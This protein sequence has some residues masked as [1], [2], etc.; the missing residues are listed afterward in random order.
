[1]PLRAP[2]I[3]HIVVRLLQ[4]LNFSSYGRSKFQP[5]VGDQMGRMVRWREPFG[6]VSY[7]EQQALHDAE[8]PALDFRYLALLLFQMRSK[9]ACERAVGVGS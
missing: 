5:L 2:R 1:M 3:Q 9:E 6:T 4:K 7:L 8:N